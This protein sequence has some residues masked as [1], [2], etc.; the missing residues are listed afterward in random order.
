[1]CRINITNYSKNN[2]FTN[3]LNQP[4]NEMKK[5]HSR[6]IDNNNGIHPIVIRV[7]CT[8]LFSEKS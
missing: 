5:Q 2:N 1:M 3:L 7:L 4:F 8:V 6:K